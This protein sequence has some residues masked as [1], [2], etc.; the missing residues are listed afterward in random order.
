LLLASYLVNV[1]TSFFHLHLVDIF[2]RTFAKDEK[3]DIKS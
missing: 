2:F 1:H 3:S